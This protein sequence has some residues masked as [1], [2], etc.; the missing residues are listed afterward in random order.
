MTENRFAKTRNV[1]FISPKKNLD[2]KGGTTDAFRDCLPVSL[3]TFKFEFERAFHEKSP[4]P[5]IQDLG[6]ASF[7]L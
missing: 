1:F 4:P 6:Y 2:S 3:D 7:L 5:G